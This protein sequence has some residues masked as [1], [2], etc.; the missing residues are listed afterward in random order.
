[1]TTAAPARIRKHESRGGSVHQTCIK[2]SARLERGSKNDRSYRPLPKQ[3]NRDSF[4]YRRIARKRQAAIYEQTC[5]ECSEPH[6]CFEVIRIRRREAVEVAGKYI[7]AAE[8][9]PKSEAWGVD[10]WT[11]RDRN[12]A[13]KK[14]REICR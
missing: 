2:T 3:F 9:Y 4:T 7:E 12:T 11:V 10:G 1:V 13:F 8:V 5:N 6:V 14:L